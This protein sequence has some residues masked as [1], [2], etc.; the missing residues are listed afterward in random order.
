MYIKYACNFIHIYD[1]HVLTQEDNLELTIQH[2]NNNNGINGTSSIL[3]STPLD[4]TVPRDG[5]TGVVSIVP[6]DEDT[7]VVSC[8]VPWN[9]DTEVVSC[10]VPWDRDTG[11]II[12]S[13]KTVVASVSSLLILQEV[14]IFECVHMYINR[15]TN[16]HKGAYKDT[17]T[18]M[19]ICLYIGIYIYMCI[20]I[21]MYVDEFIH[22]NIYTFVYMSIFL[23]IKAHI[24]TY[25]YICIFRFLSFRLSSS[26]IPCV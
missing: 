12:P 1:K 10:I 14:Y 20:F 3:E 17:W 22:K 25:V 8:I 11:V 21:Y 26:D 16:V 7:G 4:K 19:S 9:G 18:H 2:S 6:R 24:H 13:D 5:D 23:Y 15:Y